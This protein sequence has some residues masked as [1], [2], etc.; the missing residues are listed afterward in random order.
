MQSMVFSTRQVANNKLSLTIKIVLKTIRKE[1][2][3][4]VSTAES[5]LSPVTS[6]TDTAQ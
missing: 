5:I 3:A 4:S 2:S 6:V 1:N